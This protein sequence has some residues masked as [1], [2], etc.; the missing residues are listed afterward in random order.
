MLGQPDFPF[1]TNQEMNLD[2]LLSEFAKFKKSM[3]PQVNID[4]LTKTNNSGVL[5]TLNR[6][7]NKIPLGTSVIHLGRYADATQ[8]FI[9]FFRASAESGKGYVQFT[10]N[11]GIT[12]TE[13]SLQ[14]GEFVRAER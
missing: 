14:N 7:N 13:I 1:M 4:V 10:T 12:L 6:Y 2:W 11:T 3:I 9:L 5:N 8:V